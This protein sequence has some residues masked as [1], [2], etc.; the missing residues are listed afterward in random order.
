MP[1]CATMPFRISPLPFSLPFPSRAFPFVLRVVRPAGVAAADFGCV[2]L[3]QGRLCLLDGAAPVLASGSWASDA[4]P[5]A[6]DG[7]PTEKPSLDEHPVEP[8][9]VAVR[10]DLARPHLIHRYC[11]GARPDRRESGDRAWRAKHSV[12][13]RVP[14]REHRSGK[15]LSTQRPTVRL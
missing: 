13:W 8:E 7:I 1:P 9:L 4:A 11:R 3:P 12:G 14:A 6:A 5:F 2:P 10:G 15:G